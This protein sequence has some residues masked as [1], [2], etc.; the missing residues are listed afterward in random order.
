MRSLHRGNVYKP[1]A[2]L[3]R[4]EIPQTLRWRWP[5]SLDGLPWKSPV[6]SQT[7]YT[8]AEWS[9]WSINTERIA[10]AGQSSHIRNR[11]KPKRW[12]H[13]KF[14]CNS[15]P[16]PA[17]WK[18]GRGTKTIIAAIVPVVAQSLKCNIRKDRFIISNRASIMCKD[19]AW[20]DYHVTRQG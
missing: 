4:A 2:W 10:P 3:R 5:C 11:K 1:V 9:R 12:V 8:S 18:M 16:Q 17:Q 14:C 15:T 19:A 7:F 6:T 20:I 13:P